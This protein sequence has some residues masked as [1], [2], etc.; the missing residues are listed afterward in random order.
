MMNTIIK[1]P[2]IDDEAGE[3]KIVKEIPQ[4]YHFQRITAQKLLKLLENKK[5][6]DINHLWSLGS[7]AVII[8]VLLI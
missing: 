6:K 7:I 8:S 4:C 1:I 3:S 2:L 5:Q